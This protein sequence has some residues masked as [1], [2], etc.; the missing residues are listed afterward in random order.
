M[1]RLFKIYEKCSGRDARVGGA[2]AEGTLEQQH[3][4]VREL[5]CCRLYESVAK[6][7]RHEIMPS[8]ELHQ[9]AS[10]HVFTFLGA[11]QPR[12][13]LVLEGLAHNGSDLMGCGQLQQQRGY[14]L[15]GTRHNTGCVQA[16]GDPPI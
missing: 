7:L 11:E 5:V 6:K 9:P 2:P 13:Q 3:I 16:A 12:P 1:I 14:T 10:Q 4:A 15:V 8:I